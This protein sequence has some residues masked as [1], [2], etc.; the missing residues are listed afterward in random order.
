MALHDTLTISWLCLPQAF[1]LTESPLRVITEGIA[2]G[3][4]VRKLS[5]LA[6][7]E[8]AFRDLPT[9]RIALQVDAQAVR[10]HFFNAL[11]IKD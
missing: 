5:A 9:Q 2:S 8:D 7:R 10:T 3:Q 6:S 4:T 1:T 11:K